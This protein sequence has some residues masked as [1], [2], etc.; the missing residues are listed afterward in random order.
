MELF[1]FEVDGSSA[2]QPL[3]SHKDERHTNTQSRS[4][5][6]AEVPSPRVE[7]AKIDVDCHHDG[8]GAPE[9][10]P[11]PNSGSTA[12]APEQVESPPRPG[13]S[14]QGQ[15]DCRAETGTTCQE[16]PAPALLPKSSSAPVACDL[17]A[18]RV[19]SQGGL[20]ALL[21]SS[22][23]QSVDP[24]LSDLAGLVASLERISRTPFSRKDKGSLEITTDP[25]YVDP[26]NSEDS[27]PRDLHDGL[28][29]SSRDGNVTSC[30]LDAKSSDNKPFS[31]GH[32]RNRAI[33]RIST[34][35]LRSA[36]PKLTG[37]ADTPLICPEPISPTRILKVRNSIPQ[38]MKA[39]P[40]TPDDAPD[41]SR[42]VPETSANSLK[43]P[44]TKSPFQLEILATPRS[45]PKITVNLDAGD[46]KPLT[47]S[48]ESEMG[49]DT[50]KKDIPDY[51][52]SPEL[53]TDPVVGNVTSVACQL[54]E[55]ST[56]GNHR[57][58]ATEIRARSRLRLSTSQRIL[59]QDNNLRRNAEFPKRN[60][61]HKL[62]EQRP[63][64]RSNPPQGTA[65][66]NSLVY[67][68]KGRQFLLVAQDGRSRRDFDPYVSS[69]TN[70]GYLQEGDIPLAHPVHS[71]RTNSSIDGYDLTASRSF[72]S[73]LTFRRPRMLRKKF[74]DLRIRMTRSRLN[75][76]YRPAKDSGCTPQPS[77]HIGTAKPDAA[78]RLPVLRARGVRSW[79][80]RAVHIMSRRRQ[81]SRR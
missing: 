10:I 27:H 38:L 46:H 59:D 29:K 55:P 11:G 3:G 22:L 2:S 37:S 70:E 65:D 6:C 17:G 45:S 77:G 58:A 26:K 18:K 44:V 40:S 48:I 47:A 34:S 4:L 78:T 73:D 28:S 41:Q 54:G 25:G 71:T 50:L 32:R 56:S 8:S 31:K 76:R 23:R 7:G 81:A 20:A 39:L 68:R 75:L 60:V 72:S 64:S 33:M 13:K 53:P 5:D 12:M 16:T 30:Q 79:F 14:T 63:E 24:G 19:P 21:R 9:T 35:S 15:D 49:P 62:E 1:S 67:K 52:N 66:R 69:A 61:L 80:R 42:E 57:G 43:P 51:E 36:I 74:S